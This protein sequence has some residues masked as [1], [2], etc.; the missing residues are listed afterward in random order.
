[1]N[2]LVL[3]PQGFIQG[4]R[5]RIILNEIAG[6]IDNCDITPDGIIRVVSQNIG[7][8]KAKIIESDKESMTIE[9]IDLEP[10]LKRFPIHVVVAIPRPQ[11]VK[12]TIQ[13]VS[14]LGAT[15][16]H[17]IR[18]AN[19]E[20]SYLTSKAIKDFEIQKEVRQAMAQTGDSIPLQVHVHSKFKPFFEDFV[21]NNYPEA[22][23][24]VAQPS[25]GLSP[26]FSAIK[27]ETIISFGP[28]KGW[29]DYE[30]N[31]MYN[32]GFTQYSIGPRMMRLEIAVTSILG[33]L[34]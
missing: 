14:S 10:P 8:G 32:Q 15:S 31:L 33:R 6:E 34:I 3:P 24:L 9:I 22:L 16:L 27:S 7:Y 19:S 12:K 13:T 5:V 30:L 18:S 21:P 1:M 29:P 17:F 26:Y 20:K 28:E 2:Y 4:S 25:E 11:T 23:R